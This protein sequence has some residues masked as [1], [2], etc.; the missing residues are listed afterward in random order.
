M[1]EIPVE[2]P[3]SAVRRVASGAAAVAGVFGHPLANTIAQLGAVGI[4]FVVL[5]NSLGYI[6]DR[7]DWAAE[8]SEKQLDAM[9]DRAERQRQEL[10]ADSRE[11]QEKNR[12]RMKAQSKALHDMAV[13]L[14]ELRYELSR[15][16]VVTGMTKSKT[17]STKPI[18]TIQPTSPRIE[19]VIKKTGKAA[20]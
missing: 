6:Q 7:A 1:D 2:E 9:Q 19:S 15:S 3:R 10:R 11:Y 14:Q 13:E 5:M 17:F 12:E 8:H 16:R 20:K 18:T 4:M